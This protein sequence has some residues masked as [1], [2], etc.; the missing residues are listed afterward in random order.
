[1][2]KF[3]FILHFFHPDYTVGFGISQIFD[4]P[5]HALIKLAG[6]TAGPELHKT[7]KAEIIITFIRESCQV[8]T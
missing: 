6:Y 3:I 8:Y 1:M 4:S 5:N 2:L 7:L